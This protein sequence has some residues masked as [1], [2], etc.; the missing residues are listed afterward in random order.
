MKDKATQLTASRKQLLRQMPDLSTILPGSLLS[1]MVRR[2][3]P[4]CRFCENFGNCSNA[5]LRIKT[6]NGMHQSR[7]KS[8]RTWR[9][10]RSLPRNVRP[11]RKSIDDALRKTGRAKD[12]VERSQEKSCVTPPA[13]TEQ[14]C[15]SWRGY[16][17]KRT[18][19][20]FN[21][22]C[23]AHEMQIEF[24][25]AWPRLFQ[26]LRGLC[27]VRIDADGRMPRR[28]DAVNM[29]DCPQLDVFHQFKPD[30]SKRPL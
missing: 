14:R 26:F 4:G 20:R 17:Q 7:H 13:A 18:Q 10:F 15:R 12:R 6:T 1:R 9:F 25:T 22:A 5:L 19:R 11:D 16:R 23:L 27:I 24:T 28:I 2:N 30:R 3:K 29:I 8:Q 21:R